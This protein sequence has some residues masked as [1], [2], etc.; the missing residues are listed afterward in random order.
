MLGNFWTDCMPTCARPRPNACAC[1][2]REQELEREKSRL[3]AE[4]K[5]EQ[6][7]KI[8]EMEKKL[9]SLLRDFEY[10]AREIGQ[11]RS[12]PR[13]GAESLERSRAANCQVAS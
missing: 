10:H 12:G 5:K 13:G 9:E 4:G 11:C 2:A 8:K 1:E 7:A 6:Q 3:A